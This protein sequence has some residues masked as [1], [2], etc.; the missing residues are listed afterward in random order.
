MVVLPLHVVCL[1]QRIVHDGV[2][3]LEQEVPVEPLLLK[4][5]G[6]PVAVVWPHV[7]EGDLVQWE[8]LRPHFLAL[9]GCPLDAV[10]AEYVH[11]HPLRLTHELKHNVAHLGQCSRGQTALFLQLPATSRLERGQLER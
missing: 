10:C 3:T 7:S 11:V 6:K 8:P 4:Q 5:E 1:T 9:C 2:L